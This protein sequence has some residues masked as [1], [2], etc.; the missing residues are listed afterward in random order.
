MKKNEEMKIWTEYTINSYHALKKKNNQV[1]RVL[2][3]V[4]H[5]TSRHYHNREENDKMPPQV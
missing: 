2:M 1:L 5:K 3:S 4:D